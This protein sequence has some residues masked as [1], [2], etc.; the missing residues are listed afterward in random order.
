MRMLNAASAHQHVDL[1][2]TL[3]SQQSKVDASFLVF[4]PCSRT[5]HLMHVSD[6]SES[7]KIR[8]T[9]YLICKQI[10]AVH[11]Q[12]KNL[13]SNLFKKNFRKLTILGFFY[14]FK[15]R[16]LNLFKLIYL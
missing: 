13:A 1:F 16:I 9:V 2:G 5:Y 11:T 7:L 4:R 14:F 10:R 6:L 15:P 3:I 8:T 12:L